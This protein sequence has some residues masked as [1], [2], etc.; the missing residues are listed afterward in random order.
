M[1][2]SVPASQPADNDL[3]FVTLGTGGRKSMLVQG[4][5]VEQIAPFKIH[6]KSFNY[7][8]ETSPQWWEDDVWIIAVRHKADI[9]IAWIQFNEENSFLGSVIWNKLLVPFFSHL[10]CLPSLPPTPPFGLQDD[11][12]NRK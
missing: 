1:N 11:S 8:F 3:I 10:P 4:L 7:L 12:I 2:L 5:D 6:P 9:K